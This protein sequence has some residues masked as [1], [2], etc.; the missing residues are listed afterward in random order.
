[1]TLDDIEEILIRKATQTDKNEARKEIE[2]TLKHLGTC[3]LYEGF[4]ELL[5]TKDSFVE[6]CIKHNML[7]WD[8]IIDA[9][10]EIV[11][12]AFVQMSE[13]DKN[14]FKGKKHYNF[15]KKYWNDCCIAVE[16]KYEFWDAF[17]QEEF[18][19]D[20]WYEFSRELYKAVNKSIKELR[21]GWG[22]AERTVLDNT[23]V[24]QMKRAKLLIA[25]D[26]YIDPAEEF[27]LHYCLYIEA[28]MWEV[29]YMLKYVS[30]SE[31]EAVHKGIRFS[32][33]LCDFLNENYA[34][35]EDLIRKNIS[36]YNI[37][38]EERYGGYRAYVEGTS[39][40]HVYGEGESK[41]QA[42]SQLK[43]EFKDSKDRIAI[44][45]INKSF[46]DY[47]EKRANQAGQ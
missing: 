35:Y 36:E 6:Y 39:T 43:K 2:N 11:L 40:L 12:E 46:P 26:D 47:L 15:I 22:Q 45:I 33:E 24:L 32:S 19:V 30:K 4:F 21:S 28:V 37:V 17:L 5:N 8:D 18:S 41:K 14:Y 10:N 3:D 1:M 29:V 44:A 27:A 31:F 38:V 23:S 42:I 16:N 34:L 9:R 13:G 20:E 7:D 25:R